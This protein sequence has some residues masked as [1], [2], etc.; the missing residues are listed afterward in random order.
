[1]EESLELFNVNKEMANQYSKKQHTFQINSVVAGT[2]EWSV[3]TDK[4][5]ECKS[6]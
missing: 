6:K 5:L 4:L 3:C 2:M 1:M